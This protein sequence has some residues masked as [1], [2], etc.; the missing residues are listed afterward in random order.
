MRID[1]KRKKIFITIEDS[2][3]QLVESR[4]NFVKIKGKS[5]KVEIT[6][7]MYRKIIAKYLR[8]WLYDFLW[9]PVIYYFPFGFHVKKYK[10]EEKYDLDKSNYKLL[11]SKQKIYKKFESRV[12]I[13]W[14]R[15]LAPT[16]FFSFKV[17][18]MTGSTNIF[19]LAEQE[20]SKF[21]SVDELVT[22]DEHKRITTKKLKAI[23]KNEK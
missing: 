17:R 13:Y 3:D 18:K 6:Q 5:K 9:S 10:T 22:L 12:G 1:E 23:Y 16:R 11:R 2:F 4:K 19:P 14:D 21:F 15:I 20:W 8:V 7:V